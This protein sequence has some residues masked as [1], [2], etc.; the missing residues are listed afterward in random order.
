M[1]AIMIYTLFI[2]FIFA[3]VTFSCQIIPN[4]ALAEF[5]YF[6]QLPAELTLKVALHLADDKTSHGAVKNIKT[7]VCTNRYFFNRLKKDK[8]FSEDYLHAMSV[9][10]KI[11]LVFA[12]Y[13]LNTSL[14]KKIL[15]QK[16]HEEMNA[17][18]NEKK[19]F[20]MK[21]L[22]RCKGT[23]QVIIAGIHSWGSYITK[24]NDAVRL[25]KFKLLEKIGISVKENTLF[26]EPRVMHTNLQDIE[27]S[28]VTTI[29]QMYNG[30]DFFA[31]KTILYYSAYNQSIGE[32]IHIQMYH[33]TRAASERYR[34][35]RPPIAGEFEN[36]S[37]VF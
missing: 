19:P 33:R 12:A 30:A 16:H 5:A 20:M 7:L 24:L 21:H 2:L 34:M 4:D 6:M 26:I 11:S 14:S 36:E 29:T 25:P 32:L 17:R 9:N 15:I 23:D 35:R 28:S 27:N 13:Q 18:F 8:T 22:I 3:Q 37:I 10:F 31:L 1:H